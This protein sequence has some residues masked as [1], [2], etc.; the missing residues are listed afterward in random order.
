MLRESLLVLRDLSTAPWSVLLTSGPVL[1]ISVILI[2]ILLFCALH[3]LT[4]QQRVPHIREGDGSGEAQSEEKSKKHPSRYPAVDYWRGMCISFVVMYHMVG[5]FR[6][7]GLIPSGFRG[8]NYSDPCPKWNYFTFFLYYVVF[9]TACHLGRFVSPYLHYILF[10]PCTVYCICLWWRESQV[11]GVAML[12][13]CV[14]LSQALA[15]RGRII[16]WKGVFHRTIKLAVFAAM[17]SAY[18]FYRFPES[19][20]VFGAL[21][22][23]CLNSLLCLPFVKYPHLALPGFLFCQLYTMLIGT[24]PLEVDIDRP[25]LDVMPWFS[26]LGFCLL[27]VWLHDRQVHTVESLRLFPFR[28]RVPFEESVFCT[29]G[30]WVSRASASTSIGGIGSIVGHMANAR[31][32]VGTNSN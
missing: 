12:Q 5:N 22:C 23:I 17:L 30:R 31:A 29:L 26:N 21:H 19:P 10:T 25:S 9:Q 3:K 32:A 24:F 4:V 7:N 2:T 8:V 27:G 13:V 14:G 20:I 18:T 6:I 16:K 1:T 15:N 28:T 11:A